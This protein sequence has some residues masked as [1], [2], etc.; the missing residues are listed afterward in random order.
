MVPWGL[1]LSPLHSQHNADVSPLLYP[2]QGPPAHQPAAV[3]GP[4]R[5]GHP[6]PA[7]DGV[8]PAGESRVSP[9]VL[10]HSLRCCCGAGS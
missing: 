4:V 1:L 8:L 5:R 10:S 9:C 3:P 2:T 7:G 6:I